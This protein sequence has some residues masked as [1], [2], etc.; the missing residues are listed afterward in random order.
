M[1]SAISWIPADWPAP[2]GVV[3]GC[4]LRTDGVSSGKFDSLNLGARVGDEP[5][6]VAENRRRFIESCDLPRE[7][8]WLNQVHG[9]TIVVEPDFDSAPEADAILSRQP[10]TV[11]AVLTADCL[12]VVFAADDGRE[13][14]IAHAGW[15]GLCK[16]VLEA[17]VAAF[18]ASPSALLAWLGPAISQPAFEV[19]GEVRD[20]FL[21]HS[22]N[23]HSCFVKN[24]RGKWQADLY[25]LARLRLAGAG[26]DRVFGGGHC[27]FSESDRFYSY[28]R[29]GQCGRMASFVFQG[30]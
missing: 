6:T 26:V 13:L 2:P 19:G 10:G 14:A 22:A 8:V 17:T 9:N 28:R 30:A 3:A 1:T 11:C 12:P 25:E 24:G 21:Q 18:S 7:P 4:T 16:G 23:T 15:R 20:A 27:T 5:G 29:D